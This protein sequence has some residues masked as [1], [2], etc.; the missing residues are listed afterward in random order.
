MA[1]VLE[2]I[3]HA[4]VNLHELSGLPWHL[5]IPASTIALRLIFTTP[6]GILNRLRAQKQAE[7]QPLLAATSPVLKTRL[8]NSRSVRDGTLSKEQVDVLVLKERR[9]RRV[10]LFKKYKCQVWKSVL[11]MPAVQIPIWIS[12]SL[13]IR[14]MCGWSVIDSI[15]I[16]KAFGSDSF[17][18]Y[19]D[20]IRPD[21]YGI[22]PLAMGGVAMTNIEWNAVNALNPGAVV[23]ARKTGAS[24]ITTFISNV[25]RVGILFLMA[26]SFQAPPAVLLYWLSSHSFSLAQNMLF[27]K[28]LPVRNPPQQSK[29]DDK[30]TQAAPH[31][32]GPTE[33]PSD[34]PTER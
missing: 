23:A 16:E 2:P 32:T 8:L 18:W 34:A 27:D 11:I 13:V 10:E 20:L 17:L 29:I 24:N 21:P 3:H 22:L 9:N 26:A 12:M 19:S 14:A 6:L 31:E 1:T 30:V 25:S 33:S 28:Y 5:Y 7:L 4:Y 15:P